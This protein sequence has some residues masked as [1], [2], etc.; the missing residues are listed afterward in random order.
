MLQKE[1]QNMR[2]RWFLSLLAI[3]FFTIMVIVSIMSVFP[4]INE[5]IRVI[6]AL[7]I[8]FGIIANIIV[9]WVH[10][11]T[12]QYQKEIQDFQEQQYKNTLELAILSYV[13]RK[14]I[15]DENNAA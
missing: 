7:I 2:N 12:L 15:S 11:R 14:V 10:E 1:S 6:F 8:V 5:R 13:R 9:Y 3:P 4:Q